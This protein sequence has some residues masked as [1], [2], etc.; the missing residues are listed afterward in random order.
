M[1]N[2]HETE[3]HFHQQD[4]MSVYTAST[5][6]GE[7][8]NYIGEIGTLIFY[9]IRMMGNLANRP[10]SYA[11]AEL[12]LNSQTIISLNNVGLQ[13][14]DLELV[15]YPGHKGRHSF[16]L[17]YSWGKSYPPK[18]KFKGKGFGLL[19]KGIG[20]YGPTSVLGFLRHLGAKH[21]GDNSYVEA[22]G[23]AMRLLANAHLD[24]T[25]KATNS[26]D[27]ALAATDR[28]IKALPPCKNL[29]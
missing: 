6:I 9:A 19:W 10:E 29:G 25:L 14:D 24:G 5:V 8:S 15:P 17:S 13:R 11:L 23:E 1:L 4:Q 27:L 18:F 3:L 22:V 26:Y 7:D 28:A 20:Y 21:K 2:T 16:L 12:L